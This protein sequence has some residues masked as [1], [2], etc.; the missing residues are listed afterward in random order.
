VITSVSEGTPQDVD[1]A[2]DAAQQAFE[3]T[4]GLNCPGSQR[5]ILMG[6]LASL[7]EKH[8]D[9]LAAIEA[10]DNGAWITSDAIRFQRNDFFFTAGKAFNIAR[11]ADVP[12]SIDCIRYFAGW[13]DKISGNVLEV[14]SVCHCHSIFGLIQC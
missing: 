7:M 9:E 6:K 10:L 2:V 13:A 14:N 11:N 3:T 4:Y 1:L 5:S 8:S 12:L